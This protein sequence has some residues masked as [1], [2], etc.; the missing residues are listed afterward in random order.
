MNVGLDS[1]LLKTIPEIFV[2]KMLPAGRPVTI[3]VHKMVKQDRLT[4]YMGIANTLDI[5]LMPVGNHSKKL[6]SL[7]TKQKNKSEAW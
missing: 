1:S 7:R 2:T 4:I 6:D 5:N 3:I